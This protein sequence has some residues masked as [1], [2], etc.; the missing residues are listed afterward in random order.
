MNAAALDGAGHVYVT[1]RTT[2]PGWVS[3]GADTEWNG[4]ADIFVAKMSPGGTHLWS[5]YLGG[6]GDDEGLAIAVSDARSCLFVTGRTHSA[7]WVSG[8]FYPSYNGGDDAFLVRLSLDGAHQLSSYIGGAGDDWGAGVGL[9]A[10][11][12]IHLTGNTKTA[13]WISGGY[14]PS[15]NGGV[16]AFWLQLYS[17]GRTRCGT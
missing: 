10:G 8:G 3:G 7:G 13:G 17:A 16:D 6:A 9:F 2:S 5:T 1:G 12:D 4:A 14:D 11:S 15:Y